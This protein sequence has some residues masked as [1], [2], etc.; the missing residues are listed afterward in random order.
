MLIDERVELGGLALIRQPIQRDCR[1][2]C[3]FLHLL[4]ELSAWVSVKARLEATFSFEILLDCIL[5]DFDVLHDS[6]EA[7]D[8]IVQAGDDARWRKLCESEKQHQAERLDIVVIGQRV[9]D[10][11]DESREIDLVEAWAE[12]YDQYTGREWFGGRTI[13]YL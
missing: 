12:L 8:G 9:Q 13:V 2:Q 7:L 5:L 4:C 6:L 10:T 3:R 1:S 11:L